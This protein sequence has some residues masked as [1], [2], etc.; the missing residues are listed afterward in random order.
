MHQSRSHRDLADAQR[1]IDEKWYGADAN[2]LLV[3]DAAVT[4]AD[5]E[6][7]RDYPTL[8]VAFLAVRKLGRLS[9][10]DPQLSGLVSQFAQV[11]PQAMKTLQT[12]TDLERLDSAATALIIGLRIRGELEWADKTGDTAQRRIDAVR[13]QNSA[14]L[15]MIDTVR[16]GNL[17][18]QRGLTA[19]LR[20]NFSAAIGQYRR[21]VA[22]AGPPPYRHFAG[23]NAASNAAMLAAVEG[24]HDLALDWLAKASSLG[25][26]NGWSRHLALLGAN[27]A[28]ALMAIDSMDAS[29]AKHNLDLIGSA[30]EEVEL[31]PFILFADISAELAFGDAHLAYARFRS[32]GFAHGKDL[33]T[34]PAVDH[35]TFRAFLDLLIGIGEGGMALRLAKEAGSPVRAQL[36]IART[37]LLSGQPIEA[38]R[39]AGAAIHQGSLSIGDLREA[40]GVLA[41][42]QLRIGDTDAAKAAF[43]VFAKSQS[44]YH[45]AMNR[46][47]PS[48]EFEALQ[49]L[50]GIR[51]DAGPSEPTAP[52]SPVMDLPRLTPREHEILQLLA[53]GL[54]TT[55]IAERSA[56][57]PH[58]V[59][60]HV[61]NL[62][63]KLDVSSRKEAVMKAELTGLLGWSVHQ[64]DKA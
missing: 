31:W 22:K 52:A 17:D 14:I 49:S 12:S 60:T 28:R 48:E 57:S 21:A 59:R 40:H 3:I 62:Y 47:F 42:A 5:P 32:T 26:V 6:L 1:I 18:M 41:A 50:T 33:T 44:R 38:A 55:Q 23:V 61:K 10:L 11:V 58:T 54:T 39:A 43:T 25:A 9:D 51:L 8:L 20:G 45:T 16:P 34:D 35:L 46:R 36:P 7:L 64:G 19:T 30:T 53:D 63:R 27:I 56:K 13:S 24:H 4:S 29:E 15:P 37:Y 2:D